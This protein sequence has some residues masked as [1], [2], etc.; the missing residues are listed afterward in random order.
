MKLRKN[1]AIVIIDNSD[2]ILAGE[3]VDLPGQWQLPQGGIDGDETPEQALWRELEEET[4]YCEDDMNLLKISEPVSY[5]F[6]EGVIFRGGFD[7]Q[8]Q[9]YFLLKLKNSE[10]RPRTCNEFR[11]FKWTTT[12]FLIKNIVEFKKQAYSNAFEQLFGDK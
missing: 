2:K 7:G 8:E 10:K 9:I 1:V 4:G 5:I 12:E 11:D 3:R 6:P